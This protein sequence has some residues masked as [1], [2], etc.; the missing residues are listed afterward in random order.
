[1]TVGAAVK[2][3]QQKKQ[4]N[5][6]SKLK[7][8]LQLTWLLQTH[9]KENNPKDWSTK[10]WMCEFEPDKETPGSTTEIVATCGGDSICF[11]NCETGFVHKKYKQQEEVFYCMSWTVLPC[12][13]FDGVGERKVS[14]LAAAGIL[15]DIILINTEKLVCYRRIMHHKKPVDALIFHPLRPHWLFSKTFNSDRKY[16]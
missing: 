13:T 10:V 16:K 5:L 15:G 8:E 4:N 9:S 3:R 14:L 6:L 7:N 1:M 11:I 2:A 12:R